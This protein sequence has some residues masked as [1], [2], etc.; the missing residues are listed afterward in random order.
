MNWI[1][2]TVFIVAVLAVASARRYR[3]RIPGVAWHL[4]GLLPPALLFVAVLSVVEA[5]PVLAGFK[6]RFAGSL[7]IASACLLSLPA[8]LAWGRGRAIAAGIL[9]FL[10]ALI[11]WGDLIY[12]RQ[13]DT[14]LPL[15]SASTGGQLWDVR[16]SIVDLTEARDIVLLPFALAGVALAAFWPGRP[17]TA[18]APRLSR[19]VEILV[20]AATVLALSAGSV[21]GARPIFKDVRSWL[22]DRRSWKVFAWRWTLSSVGHVGAHARDIA[23]T[24]REAWEAKPLSDEQWHRV[25]AFAR[26]L[27]RRDPAE[28]FGAARGMNLLQLQL[29]GV[30]SWVIG[31]H[32]GQ[33]PITPFLNSLRERSLY[34]TNILDQTGGSPT[35]DCEYL[36]LNAQHPLP[37]GSVYFR[38]ASNDFVALPGVLRDAGYT[39]F[40]AHAYR[41]G[42]WNRSLL[43]PRFGFEQTAFANEFGRG[44]RLGWGLAD[45]VFFR[46]L[47]KMIA[48]LKKPWYTLAISLTSHHPYSP[49]PR[50]Q[51]TIDPGPLAGTRLGNYIALVRYAD[52][53]VAQFLGAL[54]KAG[55]LKD[56]LLVVYGDHE[57]KLKLNKREVRGA[58]LALDLDKRVIKHLA[59]RDWVTKKMPLFIAFPHREY[60]GTVERVGGQIDIGVTALHYLGIR[61]SGSFFGSPLVGKEGGIAP[62]F[63][64]SVAGDQALFMP[65]A[66]AGDCLDL[67]G[68][69]RRPP[70]ACDALRKRGAEAVELSLLVTMYDLARRL[71]E[72]VA[73][74]EPA[75]KR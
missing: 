2:W 29:E 35:A 75:G 46:R 54:Q 42:M 45:K 31:A 10:L 47:V 71:S 1:P 53:A 74:P 13:F 25:V 16:D 34:F 41:A 26:E 28:G 32:L 65:G 48:R 73:A 50:K 18:P 55:L 57:S 56:T 19:R 6:P 11:T 12:W 60:V 27:R 64:G 66:G 59:R 62:H 39:T 20:T 4:A 51:R 14:L 72:T 7:K 67:A 15:V 52:E 61:A 22:R 24:A 23:R 44:P 36:V 37:V 17:P 69:R 8:A 21:Y 58:K 3:S 63:D 30:Q 68:R 49:L 38:R 40:A 9:M 33:E 43:Y 70:G 5:F